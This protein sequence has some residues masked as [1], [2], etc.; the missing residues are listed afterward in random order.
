MM[1]SNVNRLVGLVG[2][3]LALSVLGAC[4]QKFELKGTDLGGDPAPDFHLK[5]E[6]GTWFS[7]ADWHGKV[8]VLTF[9]YT[10][11]P[12]ECPLIASQLHAASQ[13]LGSAMDQVAFVAVSVDPQ[14]DTPGSVRSFLQDHQLTLQ[15]HYLVGTPA[16][17]K[18]VWDAYYLGVQ[19]DPTHPGV[20]SHSTR[21]IVI[22]KRGKQRANF[23]SDL[24]VADLVF[25]VRAL[26]NQ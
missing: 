2:L 5:D 9:L 16:E 17:L 11:C 14:N 23:G 1:N 24:Q 6:N 22:D 20:I 13:Q 25:D 3:A 26:L 4:A 18:P 8:V 19:T 12:D 21:I 7:L 15:L 10:H